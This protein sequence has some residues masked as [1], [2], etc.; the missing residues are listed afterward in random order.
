VKT[1]QVAAIR[2]ETA[3]RATPWTAEELQKIEVKK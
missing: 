2:K 1:E 3:T